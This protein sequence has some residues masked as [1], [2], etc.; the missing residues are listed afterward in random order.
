MIEL[1]DPTDFDAALPDLA[2]VLQACVAGGASVNFVLP[3]SEQQAAQFWRDKVQMPHAKGQRLLFVAR[4]NGQVMGTVQL[5]LDTPPNQPHRA[6]VAKLLVHP[7]ARR[8]G[9]ARRLLAILELEAKARGRSLLTLDTLTKDVAFPLYRSIGYQ[10][11]GE[12]PGF[13]LSTD[14]KSY[15]TTCYLYKNLA[16]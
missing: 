13:A 2:R 8:Q 9:M 15:E 4:Q 11:A 12:V 6:D 1:L 7:D 16:V 10:V 3:F 14:G 5:D